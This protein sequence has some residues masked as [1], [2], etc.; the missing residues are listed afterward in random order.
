MYLKHLSL[1]IDVHS[2][3]DSIT[4]D[5]VLLW[6]LVLPWQMCEKYSLTFSFT[7]KYKRWVKAITYGI[8]WLHSYIHI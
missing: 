2:C 3:D 8:D 4:L 6:L 7:D 1:Y 5:T